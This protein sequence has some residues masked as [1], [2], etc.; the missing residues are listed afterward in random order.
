MIVI[1]TPEFRRDLRAE[2]SYYIKHN[3]AQYANEIGKRLLTACASLKK[4]PNSGKSA[5]ERF[6][7]DTD[8]KYLVVERYMIFYRVEANAVEVVRLF[9]T[10]TNILFHLFG[11]DTTDLE[12]EA[13]WG[14]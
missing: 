7:I 14:E 1:Y 10:Q 3:A 13:Y 6:G 12:S 4:S 8:M 5:A 11:V 9:N 2:K